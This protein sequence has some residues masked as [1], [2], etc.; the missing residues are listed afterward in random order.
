MRLPTS[1][2]IFYLA[3]SIVYVALYWYLIRDASQD[4]FA[5][6]NVKRFILYNIIGD[7]IGLNATF[8]PLGFRSLRRAAF[9]PL[10]NFLTPGTITGPLL[11]GIRALRS[12]WLV[13]AYALYLVLLVRALVAPTI[14]AAEV[15]PPLVLLAVMAPF[16]FVIA[17]ASRLEHYGYMLFCL[18]FDEWIFGCQCVQLALWTGAGISKLGPWFKAV[19]VSMAVNAP[20]SGLV[21]TFIR[22]LH[23]DFPR[24]VR[25]SALAG[26]LAAVGV[27]AE[28]SMG[29]LCAF[30]PTRRFGVLLTL[31]FHTFISLH[32]PFASVQEWNLFCMYVRLLLRPP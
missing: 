22:A 8:G 1:R 5:E 11:P 18:A 14:G 10:F 17:E 6:L 28:V 3:K 16:D 13:A 29:A 32:L 19:P 7:A 26:A 30:G 23:R 24:D 4:I 12:R 2:V 20:W 31:G 25:P 21:P 9:V 27:A 15:V